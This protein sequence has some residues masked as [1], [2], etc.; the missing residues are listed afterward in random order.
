MFDWLED[1]GNW[2]AD[3]AYSAGCRISAFLHALRSG[4][5]ADLLRWL[6]GACRNGAF[7]VWHRVPE[8]VRRFVTDTIGVRG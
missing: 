8:R 2:I 4:W 5:P 6:T 3:R 1:A 7:W